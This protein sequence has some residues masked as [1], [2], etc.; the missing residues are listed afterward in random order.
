M[1]PRAN[2]VCPEQLLWEAG[3]D[4]EESVLE[5]SG[6][7]RSSRLVDGTKIQALRARAES[8]EHNFPPPQLGPGRD[9]FPLPPSQFPPAPATALDTSLTS[10]TTTPPIFFTAS[11]FSRVSP[12]ASDQEMQPSTPST[13]TS[14]ATTSSAFTNSGSVEVSQV[15]VQ[16]PFPPTT[17]TTTTTTTSA[18][19]TLSHA[20]PI[21]S[22]GGNEEE[23]EAG[24]RDAWSSLNE[25]SAAETLSTIQA[26]VVVG[27]VSSH[28]SP[29]EVS[30]GVVMSGGVSG[31]G[32]CGLGV[33]PSPPSPYLLVKSSRLGDNEAEV[34]L[35][36]ITA[37]PTPPLDKPL[38]LVELLS[39]RS[40]PVVANP[41]RTTNPLPTTGSASS[42]ETTPP[43]QAPTHSPPTLSYSFPHSPQLY[44][45]SLAT[46]H[47]LGGASPLDETEPGGGGGGGRY[48]HRPRA[49]SNRA[50]A[51]L[52]R[53][54]LRPG[55]GEGRGRSH[56]SE[57]ST[58][59]L[60][61]FIDN[62]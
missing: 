35:V 36:D 8:R 51:G 1:G 59:F 43:K 19:G 21:F 18:E 29:E 30:P 26:K 7:R 3:L 13:T 16:Q 23:A 57:G 62:F 58:E 60:E 38:P 17:T 42:T 52:T 32:G 53:S 37:M 56:S 55:K 40:E 22:I 34:E 44:R 49:C 24:R 45:S 27:G 61:D 25:V 15:C 31:V 47:V 4:S 12:T 46:P 20:T 2:G 48:S 14:T 10:D 9:D 41:S 54:H 11:G 28:P 33:E 6:R 39:T 5:F 50:E